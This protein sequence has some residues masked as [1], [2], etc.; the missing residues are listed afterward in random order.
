MDKKTIEKKVNE[1]TN[2]LQDLVDKHSQLMSQ[3]D[4]I[5]KEALKKDGEIRSLKELLEEP[6][7]EVKKED[8]PGK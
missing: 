4:A 7:E 5:S 2:E 6:K 3:A 8:A 1:K